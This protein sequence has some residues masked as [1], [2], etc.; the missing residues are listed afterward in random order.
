MCVC[1]RVCVDFVIFIRQTQDQLFIFNFSFS[2]L[3]P[4]KGSNTLFK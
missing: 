1:V 3:F 4:L 2:F